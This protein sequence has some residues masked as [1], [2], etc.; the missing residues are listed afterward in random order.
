MEFESRKSKLGKPLLIILVVVVVVVEDAILH[1]RLSFKT[2]SM[3]LLYTFIR[4]SAVQ[5][6]QLK[7]IQFM[8]L[9]LIVCACKRRVVAER[10]FGGLFSS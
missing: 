6:A 8:I 7:V 10:S 4:C 9:L 1:K 3:L 2:G 5:G